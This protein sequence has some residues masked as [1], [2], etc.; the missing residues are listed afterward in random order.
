MRK[1]KQVVRTGHPALPK[2]SEQMKAWS[3]AL[4]AE[5]SGWP[6]VSARSFFGFTVLYRDDRIFAA[7]PRTRA[8]WTPNSLGFKIENYGPQISKQLSEDGRI[9][10]T[11][12]Q[13]SRWFLFEVSADTDLHDALDWLGTAYEAAGKQAKSKVRAKPK[14]S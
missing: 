8:M 9:G 7:V 14:R 6:Q 2:V 3:S 12:M 10:A 11:R 1:R 13:K 5:V 4:A